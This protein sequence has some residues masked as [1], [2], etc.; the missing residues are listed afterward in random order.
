MPAGCDRCLNGKLADVLPDR[1]LWRFSRP[2]RKCVGL[3]GLYAQ[4]ASEFASA[5]LGLQLASRSQARR[6]ATDQALQSVT[7][8][9]LAANG[10]TC[11]PWGAPAPASLASASP[12][13]HESFD[14][15]D[16]LGERHLDRT[17][18]CANG[19]S[20]RARLEL[21]CPGDEA[22]DEGS[23]A[24][25]LGYRIE[26]GGG[27]LTY[28]PDYEP[29]VRSEDDDRPWDWFS[30]YVVA[31]AVDVFAVHRGGGTRRASAVGPLERRPNRPV[32][33]RAGARRLVLFHHDP[34]R[35]DGEL[36][37]LRDR[38]AELRRTAASAEGSPRKEWRF[39]SSDAGRTS[40][41]AAAEVGQASKTS[42]V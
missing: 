35:S 5:T 18:G 21:P 14:A 12:L 22:V 16:L 3:Q 38:A 1:R 17:W 6:S 7:G 13:R 2:P 10:S 23:S 30:G 40:R 15:L 28:I 34:V 36:A 4:F 27:A 42:R 24:P 37:A 39:P 31:V 8:R 19:S 20:S 25:T 29:F 41:S 9:P 26:G 11:R 33:A 32:R